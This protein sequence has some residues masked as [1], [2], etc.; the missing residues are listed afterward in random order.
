MK[1]FRILVFDE[2]PIIQQ[3]I[4]R[5]FYAMHLDW[6]FVFSPSR[7]E[8]IEHIENRAFDAFICN[9]SGADSAE[10]ELFFTA[11]EKRPEMLRFALTNPTKKETRI[12]L[13]KYVHQ[14]IAKPFDGWDLI[15]ILEK[16]LNNGSLLE[17]DDLKRLIGK[18]KALP[19]LPR[20]Y[21]QI[22]EEINSTNVSLERIGKMIENDPAICAKVLQ[23]VN[24][25]FFGLK[26]N[27]TNPTQAITFLGVE[28]IRDLVLTCDIFSQFNPRLLKRLGLSFLWDHSISVS[29]YARAITH[30]EQFSKSMI[31]HGCT[32]GLLHDI[33]KLI[34]AQNF[35]TAY[36]IAL[37]Q[38]NNRKCA[39]VDMEIESFGASHAEI[40]AFL[41]KRW[42]LPAIV[43]A[44]VGFHH[45]PERNPTSDFSPTTAVHAAN[46]L[47]LV[48]HPYHGVGTNELDQRYLQNL[49]LMDHVP[50][51]EACCS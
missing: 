19:T 25:A 3:V 38:A 35:P 36:G 40:G 1:V 23:L 14:C 15:S 37:H 30:A 8:T 6:E 20:L 21:S 5:A 31:S 7:E 9:V 46:Y 13:A 4:R 10:A 42:G 24:S 41:L 27:V 32:A 45:F 44:A 47:D 29:G 16:T 12:E 33:G 48:K 51:W 50:M 43:V 22:T 11:Y 2:D 49:K 17:N 39:L 26:Q 18:I 34:L 28:T